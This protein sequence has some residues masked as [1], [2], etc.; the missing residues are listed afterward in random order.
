MIYVYLNLLHAEERKKNIEKCFHKANLFFNRVEAIYGKN[1]SIKLHGL[2]DPQT[3]CFLTHMK[4]LL[5]NVNLNDHLM[6]LEDDSYFNESI[7]IANQLIDTFNFDWDIIYLDNTVVEVN[8]YLELTQS[9][10]KHIHHSN[11]FTPFLHKIKPN[12]TLFGTH[13][14]IVNK[15]SINKILTILNNS[16]SAGKPIDNIYSMN[17]KN[18]N[19]SAFMILPTLVSPSVDTNFSQISPNEHPLMQDWIKFR[20]LISYK[21]FIKNESNTKSFL[22]EISEQTISIINNRLNFS[23]YGEFLP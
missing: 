9:L 20:D 7:I 3:G 4:A 1:S 13:G 14:Y 19:L 16:I 5:L 23:F 18:N 6:I 11:S 17:I 8:D 15:N 12:Q 10:Y 21:S 2:D 22:L